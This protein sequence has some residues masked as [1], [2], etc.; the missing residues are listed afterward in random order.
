MKISCQITK[1][2]IQALDSD[3]SVCM[4]AKC[5]S[6]PIS[7]V[8]TNEQFILKKRM[9]ANFHIDV[10]KTERL[11]HVYTG[12]QTDMAKPTHLSYI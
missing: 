10:L 4:A 3:R 2:F 5:Y 8:P 11:V 6:C 7:V 12:E 9:C 1:F